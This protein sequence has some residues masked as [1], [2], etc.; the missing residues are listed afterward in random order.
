MWINWRILPRD[1]RLLFISI[2]LFVCQAVTSSVG[3]EHSAEMNILNSIYFSWP[4]KAFQKI[5]YAEVMFLIRL[6]VFQS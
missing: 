1:G 4:V 5:Y 6:I 3:S 2:E